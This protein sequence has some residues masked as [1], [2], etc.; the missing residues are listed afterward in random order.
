MVNIYFADIYECILK[1]IFVV[2]CKQT[3]C[4]KRYTNAF[5][6]KINLGK[7]AGMKSFFNDHYAEQ[8]KPK[9]KILKTIAF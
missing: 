8:F 5:K 2:V 9:F 4:R 3:I 7:V 6:S 1:K